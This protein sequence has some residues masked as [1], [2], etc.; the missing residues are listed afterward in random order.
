MD[1][2]DAWNDTQ[3]FFIHEAAKAYGELVSIVSCAERIR[4]FT[5][6]ESKRKLNEDS[7][8]VIYLCFEIYALDRITKHLGI[9]MEHQ[10]FDSEQVAM[11]KTKLIP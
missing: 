11:I 8:E 9:F 7:K 1:P 4:D 3:V 5:S 2:I 6:S 10:Y